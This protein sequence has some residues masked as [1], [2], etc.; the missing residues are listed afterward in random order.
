MIFRR[1]L[2]FTFLYCITLN[3]VS[4]QQQRW[5]IGPYLGTAYSFLSS[6]GSSTDFSLTTMPNPYAGIEVHFRILNHLEIESGWGFI[7]SSYIMKYKDEKLETSRIRMRM[8][9][10]RLRSSVSISKQIKAIAALGLIYDPISIYG[11]STYELSNG[12]YLFHLTQSSSNGLLISP[13]LGI[14]LK[15]KSS[16][17]H[18]IEFQAFWGKGQFLHANAAYIH[19]PEEYRQFNHSGKTIALRYRLLFALSGKKNKNQE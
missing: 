2:L 9:P 15:G 6:E 18:E 7:H 1:T 3:P 5:L 4:A 8:F 13:S 16:L 12:S 17:Q 10:L 19:H 11:S 14:S